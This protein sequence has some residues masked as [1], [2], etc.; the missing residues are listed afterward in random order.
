M[1]G[2]RNPQHV[3]LEAKLVVAYGLFGLF[4]LFGLAVMIWAVRP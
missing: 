2:E 1:S 4:I 3:D